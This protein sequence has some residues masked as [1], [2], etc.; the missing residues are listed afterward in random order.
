MLCE[1]EKRY[2]AAIL[3]MQKAVRIEPGFAPA[4]FRLAVLYNRTGDKSQAEHES[5]MVQRIKDRDRKE[6][7]GVKV[8]K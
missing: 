2:P 5:A 3:E 4:H 8:G 1:S 7:T 6:D